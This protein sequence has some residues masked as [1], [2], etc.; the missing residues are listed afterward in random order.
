MG[1]G[2]REKWVYVST[3]KAGERG[4]W[5]GAGSTGRGRVQGANA[6][7]RSGRGEADWARSGAE[8]RP[9]DDLA[10]AL[11]EGSREEKARVG[12]AWQ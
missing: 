5:R 12:P 10:A 1:E 7:G 3:G 4:R 6:E 11:G 8:R 9:G 2:K